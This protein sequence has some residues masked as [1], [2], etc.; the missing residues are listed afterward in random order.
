[1]SL[2]RARAG[3]APPLPGNPAPSGRTGPRLADRA[4]RH[5]ETGAPGGHGAA[6]PAGLDPVVQ[7]GHDDDP[8]SAP[9][10]RPSILARAGAKLAHRSGGSSEAGGPAGPG[11]KTSSGHAEAALADGSG[12]SRETGGSAGPGAGPRAAGAGRVRGVL[13]PA[14]ALALVLTAGALAFG[15]ADEAPPTAPTAAP[16]A[17]APFDRIATGDLAHGVT[18]LQAHLRAQ[19]KDARGWATLGTAYVEQARTGGD[20]TRYPQAG[21]ALDRSLALQ[22]QDNDAA[23][24]GRAALAAARHDFHGALRDAEAA[25]KVNP[26]SERALA[27]RIDAL[28]E[29]G[30]YPKALVAAQEA[31]GRR[32]GI[33]VFTRYAYVLE[34]RGDIAGARRVLG[35]ALDSAVSPGDTAY[36]ATALGQLEWT[37][38]AY[39]PAL[40][41]FATAL[42]A[43][44]AYLP[45][46]E[47]RA[48]IQAAQG[49]T[50]SAERGLEDVVERL[51]LPGQLVALGE[52]YEARGRTAE[53]RAQYELIGTWTELARANGVDT[54][55]D[56]ALALADHGDR[57][58]ALRA[59]RA[60]WKQRQTVHTA[61][62]LAWALQ[63]NGRS[64]EALSYVGK[65]APPGCRNAV[66][67]YHRGMIERAAGKTAAAR[68]SLAAAL[69]VNPGF[70]PTGSRAARAALKALEAS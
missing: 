14:G 70:S 3:A 1:M 23:L 34:L 50:K 12:G 35:R 42:A 10:S 58:E 69:K 16:A 44:P 17:D 56:T 36:V 15:R 68:T 21:K 33:P 49:D 9:G 45:A 62:A 63:V 64:T 26:F 48:R 7:D 37:Q 13:L 47:G 19:P 66:F 46:L 11:P 41:R 38:G 5:G 40:R 18:G 24:A 43:D 39:A 61:D 31:D 67:L 6:T 65:S 4:T 55:L 32:P 59:A 29:L 53:A 8:A 27:S 60:E 30:N 28:V 52:V 22:P 51:P 57:P 54:D 2:Q 25:L 20:P